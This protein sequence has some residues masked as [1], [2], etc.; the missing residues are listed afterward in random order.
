MKKSKIFYTSCMGMGTAEFAL[1]NQYEGQGI[2][3]GKRMQAS[4]ELVELY[5]Q[6]L[7]ED[8]VELPAS[9]TYYVTIMQ[10]VVMGDVINDN[11]AMCK[12]MV[13]AMQSHIEADYAKRKAVPNDN[14]CYVGKDFAGRLDKLRP[15]LN[16]FD[17]KIIRESLA[18]TVLKHT[19][20]G[21]R[22]YL[23]R[24]QASMLREY[25]ERM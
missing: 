6:Q 12:V 10:P 19:A 8:R 5:H 13:S 21:H 18:E 20:G 24:H 14:L 16:G 15:M 2:Y 7:R 22:W 23:D 9:G 17:R 25:S 4:E 1:V 11:G 3:F